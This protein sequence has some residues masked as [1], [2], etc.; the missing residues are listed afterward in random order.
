M[1]RDDSF[2]IS[3]KKYDFLLPIYGPASNNP[4]MLYTNHGHF[5]TYCFIGTY[6][7]YC[8]AL[9]RCKYLEQNNNE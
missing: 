2:P 6:E 3:K 1:R 8:D 9:N 7:E 4:K 5:E